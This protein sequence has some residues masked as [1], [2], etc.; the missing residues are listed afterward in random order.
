MNFGQLC[1]IIK[2]DKEMNA[3]K[4]I[5]KVQLVNGEFTPQEASEV[6]NS[7]LNEKVSFHRLNRLSM[8]EA[9]IDCDTSFDGS[10]I[11]ELKQEKEDF[12][13]FYT[14]ALADGK[15]VRIS[16]NLNVEVID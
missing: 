6:V 8:N 10:R 12:K 11:D 7:L 9:N 5:H 4:I 3:T 2:K 14:E 15:R 16:G 13:T 1:I